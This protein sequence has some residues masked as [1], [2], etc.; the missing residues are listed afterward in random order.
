MAPAQTDMR[1]LEVAVPHK[2]C[3]DLS[4]TSDFGKA[5]SGLLRHGGTL[6]S[7]MC[8][9]KAAIGAGVLS[10]AGH[11]AEVGFGY[12]LSCLVV[13]GLLTV[14]GIR[15]I[16][17]A[18]IATKSWS[19]ED[20]SEELFH[21]AMSLWTGFV[22]VCNCLGAAAGYLIV[23]GQVFKVLTDCNE[24]SRKIF[25]I[26]VGI[27]VCGPLA[28]ARHVSW[29]RY[30]AMGSVAAMCLLFITVVVYLGEHGMDESVDL[31]VM[32]AGPG[33][34]TVF[35]YMNTINIVVFAY[36]NQFNVPQLTGEL[37]PEPNTN[38]M[39]VVSVI[40]S[41]ICFLLYGLVSL[42]GVLAFGVAENQKD[43]LVLDL[44][45]AR[46]QPL[47]LFTLMA[48]MFSVV[49]CFQF[50]IYPIR[51]FLGYCV[52]KARGRVANDEGSDTQ[53]YGTSLTRWIDM[54]CAVLA[55]VFAVVIAVA[56]TQLKSILDFIGAFAG[57]WVSYVIPPLFII[58][59]RRK[60]DGFTW[61]NLEIMLCV[62]FF[63][64][65]VFL[66]VFGTYAAIVG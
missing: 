62:A 54:A 56:I 39:T 37:T 66:F 40:S 5:S 41:V 48:V 14:L 50:H 45:P 26:L 49:T 33:G 58:Q 8:L 60:K 16:A 2:P 42:F 55:V 31:E 11:C 44:F 30:L 10:I 9:T 34:A 65:G 46:H 53:Y 12:T 20:I 38:K 15:M 27:F 51:Q 35:T 13:G 18:S 22:N 1:D 61:M 3:S 24:T 32:W 19:F 23:C 21:P 36:N 52:R 43:T 63:A 57:A 17:E 7:A 6:P 29:M 25:V 28:L 4:E 59:I 64:V 47:V